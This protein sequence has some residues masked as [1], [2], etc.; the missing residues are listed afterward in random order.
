M[1]QYFTTTIGRLR[2][3]AFLEGISLLVLVFIAVP[4]KYVLDN[5]Y[6]VK[7]IG[8]IH[9]ALFLLFIF[10]ALRVGIEQKWKFKETTWKVLVACF[11]PFGTF[12]IDYKILRNIKE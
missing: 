4:L 12:Y 6:W 7:N 10:N 5:A 2:L 3:F 9:G 11:I 1:K 8:P